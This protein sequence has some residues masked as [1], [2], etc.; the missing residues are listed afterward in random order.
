MKRIST[1]DYMT[2]GDS[3]TVR[4]TALQQEVEKVTDIM[5]DNMEK[6]L[7]REDQLSELD[8]KTGIVNIMILG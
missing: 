2:P 6:I 7:Q 5:Q 3:D 4:F 8:Q 1:E